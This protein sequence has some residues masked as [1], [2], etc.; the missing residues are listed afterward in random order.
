[1]SE[2]KT[3]HSFARSQLER[4]KRNK[5]K[6]F[7]KLKNII[8]EDAKILL[9]EEVDFDYFFYNKISRDTRLDFYRKRKDYYGHYGFSDLVYS[10]VLH[11]E[12][13]ENQIPSYELVVVDE[14][15]DFNYL[16]VSL[17]D[18]LAKRSPVLI[19]G[20]DDQALYE[21]LKSASAKYNRERHY[22]KSF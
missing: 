6:V 12:R 10:V 18:L 7:P 16:E 3:L 4:I 14:F 20:D 2:V 17:I 13:Y 21:S 5:V 22:V 15:Q 1:L 9:G 8:E 19:V 11:L